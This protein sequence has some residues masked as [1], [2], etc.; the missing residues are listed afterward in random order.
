MARPEIAARAN[1]SPIARKMVALRCVA[2]QGLR[3][4]MP[5]RSSEGQVRLSAP[6]ASSSAGLARVAATRAVFFLAFWL[7]ISGW[8]PNDLPVGLAAVVGATWV[9]L[10]FLPANG[11]RLRI[12]SLAALAASFLR[13]S[14]ISGTDVAWRALNPSLRLDPGLVACPLRLPAG[15]QRNAFCALSSLMPGTLPTGTGGRAAVYPRGRL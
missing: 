3:S 11:S 5:S 1:A 13:Q 8:A 7:M 6:T 14:V 4:L 2:A 15:S 12:G 9:S 10:R